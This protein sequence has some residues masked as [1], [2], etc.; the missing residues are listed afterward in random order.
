MIII[1]TTCPV[2]KCALEVGIDD[3]CGPPSEAGAECDNCG[4]IPVFVVET[5][6][7]Y[8]LGEMLYDERED[9]LQRH[10]HVLSEDLIRQI[11]EK[12][13]RRAFAENWAQAEAIDKEMEAY[14]PNSK[15]H[16]LFEQ[17]LT[18]RRW[19]VWTTVD[20]AVALCTES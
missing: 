19:S 4:A 1:I 10:G 5:H 2:C 20:K 18:L 13:E 16:E 17:L 8:S 7:S 14:G 12:A 9:S 6:V 11:A 3:S 15:E